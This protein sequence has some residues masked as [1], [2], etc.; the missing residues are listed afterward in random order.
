MAAKSK[1]KYDVFEWIKKVIDSC[2][3]LK[4]RIVAN[5]LINNFYK[6]HGDFELKTNLQLYQ[7]SKQK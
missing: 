6:M 4:H 7:M 3:T 5:T 2:E 1:D